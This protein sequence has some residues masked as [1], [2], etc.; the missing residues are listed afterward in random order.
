MPVLTTWYYIN[1]LICIPL[2][3]HTDAPWCGHCKQLA[4]IYDEL[5]EALKD[6]EDTVVAKMDST[7]NEIDMV[8]IKSFPT[9]K[10]FKKETNEV[11]YCNQSSACSNM[12]LVHVIPRVK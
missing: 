12:D 11:S 9:L 2:I 7:A 8:A 5:A 10:Y 3:S 6:I 4:P 1:C